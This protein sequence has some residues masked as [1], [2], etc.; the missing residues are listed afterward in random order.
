MTHVKLTGINYETEEHSLPHSVKASI[1]GGKCKSYNDVV[2]WQSIG[3]T[4]T[5]VID[6]WRQIADAYRDFFPHKPF[7]AQLVPGGFPPIDGNGRIIAKQTVD[8]Q[9][10]TDIL[11]EGVTEYRSQFIGQNNGLS[12]TW[13]WSQL[14]DDARQIDTGYQTAQIMGGNLRAAIDLALNA[15]AKFVEIYTTDIL[16]PDLRDA[17]AYA[18]EHLK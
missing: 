10:T 1:D 8:Y 4:R 9:V 3:Y 15:D 13:I 14:A 16:D 2:N 6:S 7:A 17:L 11:N 12:A 5:K 18:H